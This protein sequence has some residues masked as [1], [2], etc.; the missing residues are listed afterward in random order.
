MAKSTN[1]LL[2]NIEEQVNNT[3]EIEKT[4]N[5]V[6]ALRTIEQTLTRSGFICSRY[7]S[8]EDSEHEILSFEIGNESFL[9]RS[10]NLE[11]S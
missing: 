9:L 2:Y 7:T 4:E 6:E 1:E 3:I 5:Q 11:I 10:K 8:M